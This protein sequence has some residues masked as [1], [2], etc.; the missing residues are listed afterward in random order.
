LITA[1]SELL[2]S[3]GFKMSQLTLHK[4]F[5]ESTV[6]GHYW[7]DY[8]K[9]CCLSYNFLGTHA[10][11]HIE[12]EFDRESYEIHTKGSITSIVCKDFNE[13]IK[14]ALSK[15]C[16]FFAILI[17]NRENGTERKIIKDKNN[18]LAAVN[19]KI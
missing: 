9:L 15:Q 17:D 12:P 11:I 1:K 4:Q 16:K 18:E 2:S 3:G 19:I 8:R 5:N 7:G 13:F 14:F 10:F 6:S